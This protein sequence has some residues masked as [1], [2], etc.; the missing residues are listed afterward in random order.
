MRVRVTAQ[1]LLNPTV[2]DLTGSFRLYR[3]EA[4]QRLMESV[5]SKGYT[6]QMEIIGACGSRLSR[7]L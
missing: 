7:S 1:V 6:F 4:C 3:R 2:S 5:K